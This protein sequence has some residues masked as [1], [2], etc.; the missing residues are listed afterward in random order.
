MKEIRTG[1]LRREGP[2]DDLI[3]LLRS[4]IS[5]SAYTQGVLECKTTS[6]YS[7]KSERERQIPY[8]ITYMW[9]LKYDTINLSTEQKQTYRYREQTCGFQG[10]EEVGWGGEDWEIGISRDKLFNMWDG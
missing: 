8:D 6:P 2:T 9:N 10:G 4:F 1:Q 7:A 5:S 3:Q